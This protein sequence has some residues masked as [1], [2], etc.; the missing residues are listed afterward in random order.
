M[1]EK[2]CATFLASPIHFIAENEIFDPIVMMVK[3]L[4]YIFNKLLGPKGGNWISIPT[5]FLLFILGPIDAIM[6][7]M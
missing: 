1:K 3:K 5:V 2:R 4:I 6:C 7:A